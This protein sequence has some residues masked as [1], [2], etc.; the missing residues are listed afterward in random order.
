MSMEKTGDNLAWAL[1]TL[2]QMGHLRG[3]PQEEN[4]RILTAR[5]FLT[6]VGPYEPP[7]YEIDPGSDPPPKFFAPTWFTYQETADWVMD[8][9]MENNE[10]VFPSMGDIRKAYVKGISAKWA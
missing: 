4:Q 6:I 10:G 7:P 9:L 2:S 5:A 3:Y 1:E 8:Y